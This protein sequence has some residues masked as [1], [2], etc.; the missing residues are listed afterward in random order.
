MERY[1]KRLGDT[2]FTSQW[3]ERSEICK[4]RT[5]ASIQKSAGEA[6]RFGGRI[7]WPLNMEAKVFQ[8]SR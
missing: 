2:S 4:L 1:D 6:R 7:D 8:R 3:A 5:I